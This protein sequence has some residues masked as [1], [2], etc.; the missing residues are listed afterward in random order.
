MKEQNSL[1][2]NNKNTLKKGGRRKKASLASNPHHTYF[3]DHP[4]INYKLSN[5]KINVT[6]GGLDSARQELDSGTASG[7]AG[8]LHRKSER[9]EDEGQGARGETGTKQ[10]PR[11]QCRPSHSPNTWELC[12]LGGRRAR[13]AH[14]LHPL[15]LFLRD[16][17]NRT[18]RLLAGIPLTGPRVLWTSQCAQTSFVCLTSISL[19]KPFLELLASSTSCLQVL[20]SPLLL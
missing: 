9:R 2:S 10:A 8:S 19:S 4:N 17:V 16:L 5:G 20:P 6:P 18:P 14:P 11:E 13:G 3:S 1:K 7:R 15:P 12:A